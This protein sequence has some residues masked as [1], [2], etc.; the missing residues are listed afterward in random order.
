MLLDVA[1]VEIEFH[2]QVMR[3]TY[4]REQQV[5]Q[6]IWGCDVIKTRSYS[7]PGIRRIANWLGDYCRVDWDAL[8]SNCV[9]YTRFGCLDDQRVN[10]LPYLFHRLHT[11]YGGLVR[12]RKG[13]VIATIADM[14]WANNAW[15]SASC[16][17]RGVSLELVGSGCIGQIDATG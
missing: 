11:N 13:S 17:S 9:L 6:L 5:R 3:K 10:S 14:V 7:Q 4:I 15:Y 16:K 1:L 8:F 12:S 2:M